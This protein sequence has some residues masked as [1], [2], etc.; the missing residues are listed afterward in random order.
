MIDSQKLDIV[1]TYLV[2]LGK[3]ADADPI[4]VEA[5]KRQVRLALQV[6]DKP[7]GK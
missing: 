6:I 2:H 7:K 5:L 4:D 3:L 1:R